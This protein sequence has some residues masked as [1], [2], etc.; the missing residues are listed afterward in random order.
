MRGDDVLL[1]IPARVV[2]IRAQKLSD[3]DLART[4]AAWADQRKPT[5]KRRWLEASKQFDRAVAEG[6]K[7]LFGIEVPYERDLGF[8]WTVLR[9]VRSALV[10]AG[11]DYQAESIAW[12][13]ERADER[14]KATNARRAKAKARSRR[15]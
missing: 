9:E 12:A 10:D 8:N 7:F 5:N 14:R 13:R 15:V 4:K 3:L 2:S 1:M 11:I 6:G